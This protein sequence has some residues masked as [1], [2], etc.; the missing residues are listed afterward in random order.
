MYPYVLYNYVEEKSLIINI[1]VLVISLS[2][3]MYHP[4]IAENSMSL[5]IGRC[6]SKMF[7]S[8]NRLLTAN[9]NITI[10]THIATVFD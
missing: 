8:D 4:K 9:E 1:D 10:D 2:S 7:T 5:K 6:A 3:S